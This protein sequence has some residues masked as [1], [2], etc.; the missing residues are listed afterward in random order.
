MSLSQI[1]PKSDVGAVDYSRRVESTL[2]SRLNLRNRPHLLLSTTAALLKVSSISDLLIDVT[3]PFQRQVASL[4][5]FCADSKTTATY[6]LVLATTFDIALED[7]RMTL[8]LS[9]VHLLALAFGIF[10]NDSHL[11]L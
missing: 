5:Q 11:S 10:C 8:A 2:I 4:E 6:C 3:Q 9:L 7:R 1:S